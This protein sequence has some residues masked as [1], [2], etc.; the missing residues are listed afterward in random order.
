MT[1]AEKKMTEKISIC[2]L[3][4]KSMFWSIW[5]LRRI[6]RATPSYS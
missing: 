3:N 2:Y 5:R 1:A 6:F 4:S